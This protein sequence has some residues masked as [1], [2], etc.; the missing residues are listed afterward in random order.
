MNYSEYFNKVI[1][2]ILYQIYTPNDFFSLE[3]LNGSLHHFL[4]IINHIFII[5]S[6]LPN[7]E[8]LFFGYKMNL[9]ETKLFS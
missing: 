9:S 7:Y 6:Y 5:T 1:A 3:L 8:F 4:Y 2:A